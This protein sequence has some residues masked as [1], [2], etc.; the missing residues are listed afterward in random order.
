MKLSQLLSDIK[1][2]EDEDM[3]FSVISPE[4]AIELNIDIS[5]KTISDLSP[6]DY[7][8]IIEYINFALFHNLME[9]V[10]NKDIEDK[11][12][13]LIDEIENIQNK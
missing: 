2:Q 10:M 8:N 12:K 7:E 11:L 5:K 3:D 9:N 4:E 1:E 13:N 6:S